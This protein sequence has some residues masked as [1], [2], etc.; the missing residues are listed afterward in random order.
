ML[1]AIPHVVWTA[2]ADGATTYLNRRGSQLIG[3][4][5]DQLVDWNWLQLLHPDDVDRSRQCWHSAVSTGTE[6]V[7]EYRLRQADGTYRWYLTQ[8]VPLQG[9]DGCPSGWLGTWTDIDERRRAE[10]RHARDAHLLASV[11][12]CVIVTDASG[13]V[14]YWNDAAT[15]TYGWTAEEMC[16]QPLLNRFPEPER[17]SV[18]EL[19]RQIAAGH[20]WR[21]EFEDYHKDGSR[22]WIDGR[23]ARIC[24]ASGRLIGIMGT[25]H[26]IT[27][28][29]RA[30]AE[31]DQMTARLRLQI[32]RMPLAYLLFDG[33]L[34]L[35]DWNTA[36]ERIFGYARDEVLGMMPPFE[37][38]L[39]PSAWPAGADVLGRLRGGDMAA[40]A[41]NENLTKGGGRSP[42]SGRIRRCSIGTACSSA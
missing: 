3:V 20:D 6:Y 8:A 9:A 5:A 12:D 2:S 1:E 7:N 34:R 27:A 36:A 23:V 37:K 10:E 22:L 30:E 4:T 33:D 13:I 41:I 21:G 18:A 35:V 15:A 31:R 32:D 29:K 40:H 38:I 11:R 16:G 42:A 26:D 39:P 25:S 19:M 28:R 24:D 14:T 17:A